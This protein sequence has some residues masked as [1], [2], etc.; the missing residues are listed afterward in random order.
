MRLILKE[1]R[2]PYLHRIPI[3]SFC[4]DHTLLFIFLF[5]ISLLSTDY[6]RAQLPMVKINTDNALSQEFTDCS[7]TLDDTISLKA[8]IRF[9]GASALSKQKKSFAVK[10][11]YQDGEKC[12]TS[13]LGMRKDNYW[14]LDAMAIDVARMRNRVSMDLW[15][16]FS[17]ASYI[18]KN[19][20]D[21][22][23]GT[24]GRFVELYLNDVYWGIYCLSERLDRKQ[25]K[26]K[27]VDENGVKGILYKSK[28]WSTL[29]S[30]DSNYY[31]FN[32]D[33]DQWNGWEVSYPDI[34]DNEPI[35]WQPLA[36]VIHWLSYSSSQEIAEGLNSKIDIPVWQDY[37]LLMEFICAGDNICKNQYV[38]FYNVRKEDRMLGVAPWDMDHSWGRDYAG[39][40]TSKTNAHYNLLTNYNRI[41]KLLEEH[42]SLLENTY[43]DRYAQLRIAFFTAESLK[44]RFEK[45]FKLFRQSGAAQRE[46][47]RW[48]ATD[49]IELDF[50]KE[51]Q[52]IN[53][54]IEERI[55]YMD[56]KYNYSYS[57]I[58]VP[59][60]N[61]LHNQ[62][63]Y[64]IQG[65]VI[66]KKNVF[67]TLS[68]G[69]YILNG[70]KYAK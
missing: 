12:D 70:K 31:V 41:G 42:E 19:E 25:L 40:I 15:N 50:E 22:C 52:Y 66:G 58:A 45:Y 39:K 1:N 44:N 36:D 3:L 48:N 53:D 23:N 49:G 47:E 51:Q 11:K 60:S 16:D 69:L 67:N 5:W 57:H 8:D 2:N 56:N 62:L 55:C 27:K 13:L 21:A 14:I 35:D 46:I 30:K 37:F 32:N 17:R 7:F 34:K 10:L 20:S 26:L 33:N 54:W 43:A 68:P 28:S 18:N 24:R 64:N 63:I 4:K 59:H 61:E 38:Y 6:A 9:R 29:Y 65:Q